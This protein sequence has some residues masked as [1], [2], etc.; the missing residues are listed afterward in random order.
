MNPY[1]RQLLKLLVFQMLTLSDLR[2]ITGFIDRKEAVLSLPPELRQ[3]GLTCETFIIDF[4]SMNENVGK[5]TSQDF[6]ESFKGL[7]ELGRARLPYPLVYVIVRGVVLET[8]ESMLRTCF[9]RERDPADGY[10]VSLDAF[11]VLLYNPSDK[12]KHMIV[13]WDD[14]LEYMDKATDPYAHPDIQRAAAAYLDARDRIADCILFYGQFLIIM[15]NTKNVLHADVSR[16]KST[17]ASIPTEARRW[18]KARY[19]LLHPN[20]PPDSTVNKGGSHTSPRPHL[21]RGHFRMVPHGHGRTERRQVWIDPCFVN[22]VPD[23]PRE[24]Y[25]F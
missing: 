5:M 23:E 19:T 25:V 10:E 3:Q 24:T 11:P 6:Q 20:P 22:G 9:Y 16:A 8:Q 1:P 15:L 17:V 18:G 14:K 12:F 7:Q 2:H 13:T 21:R 4:K